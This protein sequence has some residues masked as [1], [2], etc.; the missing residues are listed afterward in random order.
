MVWKR[1]YVIEFF[2]SDT[3]VLGLAEP[4]SISFLRLSTSILVKKPKWIKW[5]FLYSGT[6]EEV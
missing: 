5:N 4:F 3:E 6:K 1:S 2:S